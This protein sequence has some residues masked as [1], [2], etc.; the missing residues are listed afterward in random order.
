MDNKKRKANETQ[1]VSWT[2]IEHGRRIYFFEINGKF[3]WK[4]RYFKE[5]DQNELTIRFWQE[6]YDE[7]NILREVHEKYPIDKGHKKIEHDN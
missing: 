3:G 7:K 1:F 6:I 4:A 5:V 2:E